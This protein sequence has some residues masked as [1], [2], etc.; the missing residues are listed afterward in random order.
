MDNV[1]VDASA[2]ESGGSAWTQGS[3]GQKV[4]RNAR[5][6][7]QEFGSVTK[8]VG[9]EF[10]LDAAPASVFRVCVVMS[11]NGCVGLRSPQVESSGDASQSFGGALLGDIKNN[12]SL[13]CK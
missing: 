9:D 6:G 12:T 1:L 10:G 3:S 8:G 7:L 4:K 2:Q 11:V 5:G 13:N